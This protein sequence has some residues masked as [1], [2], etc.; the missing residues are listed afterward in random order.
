MK[1]LVILSKESVFSGYIKCGMA[2]L[3]DS[4]AASMTDRYDVSLIVAKGENRIPSLTGM[5]RQIDEN[6][7][8]MTFAKVHYYMIDLEMWEEKSIK[9][10]NHIKPD[11][12]HNMDNPDVLLKLEERPNKALFTFDS[13][14]YATEHAQYLSYYDSVNHNSKILARQI[15]R[16]RSALSSMLSQT[17]FTG[18]TPGVLTQYFTPTKGLLIP[19]PYSK[20]NYQGKD[21]CKKR[22]LEAYGISGNPFICLTMCRLIQEKGLDYIIE[23]VEDIGRLGG[24]LIVVG[25]GDD[26]YE[27]TFKKLSYKYDHVYF[28]NKYASP[29]RL[30]SLLAGADF[31][32]QPSIFENAGLMPLTALS[33]GTIPI[34]SLVGGLNDS[35]NEENCIPVYMNNVAQAIEQAALIYQDK[36]QLNAFRDICMSQKI[37]WED[38]KQDY[39]NLYEN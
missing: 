26:Y 17:H 37:S 30:P 4:L 35:F 25:I 19:S 34:I 3:A 10:I 13:T 33:Y 21:I 20:S 14:D 5:V 1:K 29:A 22:L 31:Y 32:L 16:S 12:F 18:I 9:L 2:E 27:A 8:G 36:T 7:Y 38:R 24:V 15:Q 23:A 11:I 6:V 39:V 28:T